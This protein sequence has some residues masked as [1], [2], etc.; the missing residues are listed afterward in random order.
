MRI[1]EIYK[2]VKENVK[3][4]LEPTMFAL[5]ELCLKHFRRSSYVLEYY[6][7]LFSTKERSNGLHENEEKDG[8]GR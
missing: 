5:L 4:S 1:L 7:N 8:E 2:F 6:N 3:S